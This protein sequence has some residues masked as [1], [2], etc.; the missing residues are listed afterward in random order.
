YHY[1]KAQKIYSALNN[2]FYSGRM[3]YNMALVQ[4]DIKDYTGS[5][6]STIKAIELLKP[7]NKYEQLYNC[8]NNLGVLSNALEEYDRALTYHQE[9]LG[10]LKK[11]KEKDNLEQATE[12]NI[13]VVYE[14]L[15]QHKLAIVQF[16]KVLRSR[17]LRETDAKFYAKV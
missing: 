17:D 16:S 5:E 6:I 13:G 15:G 8:Y 2:K 12:N 4:S 3:L 7:L 10:Y 1:S 14:G 11:V 9:A